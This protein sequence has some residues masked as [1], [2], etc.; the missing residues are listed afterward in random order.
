[1]LPI[2]AIENLITMI[3]TRYT[4]LEKQVFPMLMHYS[5]RVVKLET[6]LLTAIIETNKKY[7]FLLLIFNLIG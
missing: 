4:Y 3:E 6:T 5:S 2:K 7:A 1:M